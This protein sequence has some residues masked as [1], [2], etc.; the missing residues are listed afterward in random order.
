M[1]SFISRHRVFA[2]YLLSLLWL[3]ATIFAF[4][5]VDGRPFTNFWK[6]LGLIAGVGL[7]YVLAWTA[8]S[9]IGCGRIVS[10]CFQAPSRLQGGRRIALVALVV[11]YGLVVVIHFSFLGSIPVLEAA[12]GR[13]DLAISIIRQNSYFELPWMMRYASDYSLKALGPGLLLL[14]YYFRSR[15]FWVVLVI[16][17]IYSVGLFARIL[18]LVLCLPLLVYQLLWRRWLHCAGTCAIMLVMIFSVSQLSS[19]SIEEND[20]A[21]TKVER[22]GWE[23]V[24]YGLYQRVLIV[25]GQVME[26]W[27]DYYTDTSS[28]EHGCAYRILARVMGC[29]YVHVPSKL[30]AVYYPDNVRQGM[31][32]SLNAASFMTEYANFGLYGFV[33]SSLLGG[34][35]FSGVMLIYQGHPLALPMNIPLIVT[36][37]ESNFSHSV[38]SGSG[39]V[40]MTLLYLYF[41]V[42][43]RELGRH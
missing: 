20:G 1:F 18:P 16:G 23:S 27:F 7:V 36:L 19:V 24:S 35:F 34:L 43:N 30:Y 22:A 12:F 21:A 15:L 26:Q 31:F 4:T 6:V 11:I 40:F 25:P 5:S 29:E 3:V 10:L 32:G 14:T 38:N 9:R 8:I 17:G 42:F 33:L 41:I 13:S 28:F 37:M 39:W 2:A